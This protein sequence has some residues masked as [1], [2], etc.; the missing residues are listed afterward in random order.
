[1]ENQRTDTRGTEG[2]DTAKSQKFLELVNSP[3]R[4]LPKL[5]KVNEGHVGPGF[6]VEELLPSVR[7]VRDAIRYVLYRMLGI[8]AETK[9]DERTRRMYRGSCEIHLRNL[10]ALVDPRWEKRLAPYIQREFSLIAKT[11]RDA[12]SA[13]LHVYRSP[14]NK[15]P[16]MA[17]CRWCQGYFIV[18]EDEEFCSEPCKQKYLQVKGKE[19]DK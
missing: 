3:P 12:A 8:G 16:N 6:S 10:E 2:R 9:L 15:W 14:P 17:T 5:I 7:F 19:R 18:E 13:F 1:M 4:L 11:A